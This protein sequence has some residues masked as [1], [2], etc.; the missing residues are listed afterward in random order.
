M[1]HLFILHFLLTA[2]AVFPPQL[3]QRNLKNDFLNDLEKKN[4]EV[5]HLLIAFR[6]KVK[7][8][9]CQQVLKSLKPLESDMSYTYK[10]PIKQQ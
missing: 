7:N 10:F 2:F 9:V 6:E 1:N 8:F 5:Q 4:M 3:K